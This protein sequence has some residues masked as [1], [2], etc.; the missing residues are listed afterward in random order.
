MRQQLQRGLAV[1]DEV[2]VDEI[3]R[4]ADTV[5]KQLFEFGRDLL[6]RLD[7]RVAA[8]EPGNIAK[9][10]LV[11]TAARVLDAAEEIA[12]ELGKLVSGHRKTRHVETID[13]LD[14]DLPL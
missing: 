9:L 13:R 3:D 6:R 4:A 10:A 14:H 12:L 2:V 5:F 11:R 1:A 8:V 7:A